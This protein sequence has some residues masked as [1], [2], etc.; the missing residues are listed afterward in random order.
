MSGGITHK[1]KAAYQPNRQTSAADSNLHLSA[2]LF[3]G[4]LCLLCAVNK[5]RWTT[6][7]HSRS[8]VQADTYQAKPRKPV[9]EA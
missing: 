9:K 2:V 7:T 4:H 6:K 1:T 5:R 3:L 8:T